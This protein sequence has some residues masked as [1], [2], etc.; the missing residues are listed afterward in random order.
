M[1]TRPHVPHRAEPS[2]QAYQILRFAFTIAPILAGLDKFFY[3]LTNWSQ[4][5]SAPFNVLG[6]PE[7][8]LMV[9]GVIEIIVGILVWIKPK[10]FAYVFAAWLL[11]IIINL[12][13]LGGYFDIA[14]HD[15]GLMLG[16]LALARISIIYDLPKKK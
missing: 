12:L 2:Y 10:V 8:T 14:L 3:V 16:A 7:T 11:V 15:F 9:V 13:I 5:L 6:N 1:T 4:Y